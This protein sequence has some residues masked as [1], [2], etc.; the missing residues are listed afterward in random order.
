M[1]RLNLRKYFLRGEISHSQPLRKN[2]TAYIIKLRLQFKKGRKTKCFTR[3]RGNNRTMRKQQ[4]KQHCK[5]FNHQTCCLN[6]SA[7]KFSYFG[8]EAIPRSGLCEPNEERG[9][10]LDLKVCRRVMNSAQPKYG[11]CSRK[12][13]RSR[14]I[15]SLN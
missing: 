15:K 2:S 12:Y 5:N 7:A 13:L 9:G 14:S 4:C 6:I 8:A 1:R 11:N 10:I 3:R